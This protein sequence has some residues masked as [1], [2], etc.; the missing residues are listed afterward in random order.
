MLL[1]RAVVLPSK[2]GA[3][4]DSGWQL[5]PRSAVTEGV[6]TFKGAPLLPGAL[7][8]RTTRLC[9]LP[10]TI[11]AEMYGETNDSTVSDSY[12]R[13]KS[14]LRLSFLHALRSLR[15]NSVA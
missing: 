10:F 5:I 11:T 6:G 15:D 14:S 12:S 8:S 4:E 9:A 7:R 2:D 13:G 1:R 3:P